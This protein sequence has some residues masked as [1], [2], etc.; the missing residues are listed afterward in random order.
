MADNITD[1][2]DIIRKIE[3]KKILLPD[4][5]RE[6]VW[7][8]EE[9]QRKL[10][11]SILAKMPIG[12]ILLLKS[13]AEEYSSKLIGNKKEVDIRDIEDDVEF[14]LDGQQRITVLANVFS[15]IIFESCSKVSELVS[16][17]LKRRFFL[18]IPTWKKCRNEKDLFGVHNLVFKIQNPDSEDPD[19]L[20]GDILDFIVS[21]NFKEKELETQPYHPNRE[22]STDLDDFCLTY[23]EGYL[24]PLFLLIPTEKKTKANYFAL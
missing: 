7:K 16:T 12:S 17:S 24:V 8:D 14:L 23:K 21:V 1:F 18:R 6:F 3:T 4:F 22:L 13:R 9:Q 10:V 11:A 15:N 19:F 20:S 2:Q 5:Q